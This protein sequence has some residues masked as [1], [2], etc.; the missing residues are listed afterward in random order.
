MELRQLQV[1]AERQAE[2]FDLARL[3]DVAPHG[4]GSTGDSRR[5]GMTHDQIFAYPVKRHERLHG[6]RGYTDYKSFK[7]WLRD[8]FQFC[9]V[10][11]LWREVWCHDGENA[12][13][14]DHFLSR[15]SHPNKYNDYDNLLYA[16]NGCNSIKRDEILPQDPCEVGWGNHLRSD[17]DGTVFAVTD[18]GSRCV[19]KCGL[20][21][22]LL[23]LARR[24]MHR[25][26]RELDAAETESAKSLVRAS[27]LSTRL[28]RPFASKAANRQYASRRNRRQPL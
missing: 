8:E 22:P 11:C 12:F 15:A 28:A 2:E 13:G 6:P 3:K 18:L 26:L 23:V 4:G 24:Q 17:S 16:C 10:Y 27:V 20:N 5:L 25:L 19:E 21:R 9:C 7:P 14:V 1:L